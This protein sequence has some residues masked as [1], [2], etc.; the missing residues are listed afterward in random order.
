[1]FTGTYHTFLSG[2][3]QTQSTSPP[4]FSTYFQT[5]L[6]CRL[7]KLIHMAYLSYMTKRAWNNLA[8]T[9]K[10]MN[11][12]QPYR[13][14]KSPLKS[15]TTENERKLKIPRISECACLLVVEDEASLPWMQSPL[16]Y[17]I[18]IHMNPVHTFITNISTISFNYL[19]LLLCRNIL[20]S[21]LKFEI[22]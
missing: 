10:V 5:I 2:A 7:S 4:V 20:N 1:M 3:K 14:K 17:L 18:M 9:N 21:H 15:E 22:L 8:N 6:W 11:Y 12:N 16:A 19:F 13:Y